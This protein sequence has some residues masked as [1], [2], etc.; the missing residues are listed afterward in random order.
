[1]SVK[2]LVHRL[3]LRHLLVLIH[4]LTS[5][6]EEKAQ[7]IIEYSLIL[8]FVAIVALGISRA[9]TIGSHVNGII[10][11]MAGLFH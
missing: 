4:K 5:M 11:A 1:M 6:E 10:A 7:G 2:H 8:A 3:H 9:D